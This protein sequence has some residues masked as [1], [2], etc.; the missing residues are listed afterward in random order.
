MA[1]YKIEG[2]PGYTQFDNELFP[3]G[4]CNT[5]SVAMVVDYF[6]YGVVKGPY[7]R[8]ADNLTYYCTQHKLDRHELAVLDQLL[9]KFGV[10]DE[11]SFTTSMDE[12][13][14]WLRSGKPAIVQG[15]FTDSGHI[16]VVLGYD[17]EKGVFICN[18]PAGTWRPV[19]H[20]GG[21]GW[22]PGYGVEYPS[23]WFRAKAAPD[24]NV[25][26]HLCSFDHSKPLA[27][28]TPKTPAKPAVKP[29]AALTGKPTLKKQ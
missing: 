22:T 14:A 11:S 18:D 12:L 27:L 24:G 16:M 20:Y 15:E 13:K 8:T 2:M 23:A 21:E 19:F 28:E 3:D 5:T 9:E 7:A 6:H 26:A 17:E 25:W 10:S 1:R 4:T 29:A